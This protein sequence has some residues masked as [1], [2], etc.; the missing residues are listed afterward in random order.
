MSLPQTFRRSTLYT[1]IVI[2]L[3]GIS[4]PLFAQSDIEEVIVT[5]Q[6]REQAVLDVPQAISVVSTEEIENMGATD[7]SQIQAAIPSLTVNTNPNGNND[8]VILRNISF[9]SANGLPTVGRFIDEANVNADRSGFGITFPML[10]LDRVEVLK[11]P[12][13]TL[14]G[15]SSIGGAI[16][17]ITK[18]PNLVGDTD[19][20]V[21]TNVNSIDGG[22]NGY[23]V[24]AAGN[25]LSTDTFGLR[26]MGYKE[27]KP[28]WVDND[29][30]GKEA[31]EQERESYRLKALWAPIDAFSADLLY[32]HYE[33][34]QAANGRSETDFTNHGFTATSI[35][36]DWDL[37]TLTL[38]WDIT[39]EI[40]LTSATSKLD[41]KANSPTDVSG[42]VPVVE[43]FFPGTTVYAPQFGNEITVD[44][45]VELIGYETPGVIDNISHETRLNGVFRDNIYWTA[46]FYW[47]DAEYSADSGS[48]YW[49]DPDATGAGAG[50]AT[51]V[52]QSTEAYAL[53]ADV[54]YQFADA[55]EATFGLR[56]YW[57][58]RYSNSSGIS[59]GTPRGFSDT[60]KNDSTIGRVVLKYAYDEN[61]IAYA[62][63]SQGFRSGGIQTAETFNTSG[64]TVPNT[65]DPEDLITYELG[66]KGRT[67]G[68]DLRYELATYFS[69]YT[70]VQIVEPVLVLSAVVS[71]G[72][73][74]IKGFESALSYD[75]TPNLFV[76]FTYSYNDA[77][78][79]EATAQHDKGEPFDG[80]P[81]YST[82]GLSADYSF[83]WSSQIRGHFR[84]DYF[85]Q[86]GQEQNSKD[87]SFDILNQ[88]YEGVKQLNARLGWLLD[89]WSAYLYAE[90][91]TNEEK[92]LRRPFR[93][94]IDYVIQ[95]PRSLGLTVRYQF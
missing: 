91:L 45:P 2:T 81:M 1:G 90:N 25:V 39:P 48:I 6:K 88:Q 22:G 70:N 58:E 30:W 53:F 62:S 44:Q 27:T 43:R 92:Q 23:R 31:N 68:G 9:D 20:F 84:M 3:A 60:V 94:T 36:E 95:P 86:D 13:G 89:D 64:G 46:G 33:A 29:Y 93:G 15:E 74:E 65:F 37:A 40:S 82:L 24:T 28:G 51:N 38:H 5:A 49:P 26:L 34:A 11:G 17:Y 87:G 66:L 54:S 72:K 4:Q 77:Q 73:A 85:S 52:Y 41:R 7:L 16:K 80:V 47:K 21:E 67:L 78:Y 75:I 18:N 57:D 79:T 63:A 50:H 76:N 55:W 12:Q 14:Y 10:D 56:Q 8:T 32:Q 61:T 69:D 59:F 19:L 35:Y 42:W 71:G 83:N